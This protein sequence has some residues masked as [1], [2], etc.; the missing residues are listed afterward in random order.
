MIVIKN[1]DVKRIFRG[2]SSKLYRDFQEISSEIHHRGN[3]GTFREGRLKKFLEN[4]RLP[5]KFGIGSGE[6]VGYA[7]NTSKQSDLII[8]D[9]L[10]G[11]ALIYDEQVQVYPIESVYGVI[12][13][14]SCLS[15]TELI[16]SL[17]NIKS[18]KLLS[19]NEP[20]K[21]FY[22]D[23]LVSYPR[24][25][26]FGIIFAYSLANNS[27]NSLTENLRE[28]ESKHD[29]SL[30]PNIVVVLEEGIIYHYNKNQRIFYNESILN[31]TSVFSLE[32]KTDT[33]YHFYSILIDLCS[34]MSLGPVTLDRYF[35]P[36]DQMGKYLVRNHY[37]VSNLCQK[38]DEPVYRLNL[39]FIDKI[40]QFCKRTGKIKMGDLFIKQSGSIPLGTNEDYLNDEVYLYDPDNLPGIHEVANFFESNEKGVFATQKMQMP[41]SYI[42]IDGEIYFIPEA[43][44]EPGDIELIQGKTRGNI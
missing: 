3:Q 15:K 8:Y 33:L 10:N 12:E 20:I 32:H 5:N 42:E 4:G 6:I 7:S 23:R 41:F 30:Y 36:S 19:P 39:R 37:R 44:I 2:I 18:V 17:D 11:I 13:V 25:K 28:W 31:A 38:D 26:P 22:S 34:N 16:K 35:K 14:K 43:Y 24:P 21:K 1:M 29:K 40:V 9:Q 27:L